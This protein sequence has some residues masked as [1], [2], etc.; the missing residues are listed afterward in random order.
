MSDLMTT[1][2]ETSIHCLLAIIS[3]FNMNIIMIDSNKKFLLEFTSNNNQENNSTYLIKKDNRGKYHINTDPIS[4]EHIDKLKN[5]LI[6]LE[7]YMKPLKSISGYKIEELELLSQKIGI[8]SLD[9]N[10]KR[11]K[12]QELYDLIAEIVKWV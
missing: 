5:E 8:D 9:K 4:N 1:Q 2:K 7:N 12:K 3:M 6:C 10:G 11:Y